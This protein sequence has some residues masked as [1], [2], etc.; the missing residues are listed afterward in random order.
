MMLLQKSKMFLFF[1]FNFAITLHLRQVSLKPEQK[2]ESS[3]CSWLVGD[4][5]NTYAGVKL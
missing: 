3:L 4:N 2:S 5:L 1:I